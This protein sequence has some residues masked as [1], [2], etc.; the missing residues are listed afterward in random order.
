MQATN[1]LVTYNWNPTTQL[2][3]YLAAQ[4]K[5]AAGVAGSQAK[6]VAVGDSTTLG[7]GGA[8]N[9]YRPTVSYPAQL[10]LDLSQDGVAR[11]E[12]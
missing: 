7:Y 9:D 8:A 5:V 10:A 4:A 2:A 1:N 12:R 6:I 11:T 3:R